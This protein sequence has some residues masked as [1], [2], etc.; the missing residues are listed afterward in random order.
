[1]N[2]YGH[3]LSGNPLA[4]LGFNQ[5][6][7]WT[8]TMFQNDDLDMFLEKPNPAN[9]DQVWSNGRWTDLEIEHEIIKVKGGKDVNLK[10]RIS[11]HGPIINDFLDTLNQEKKPVAVSWGFHDFTN[12][13][14]NGVYDLAHLDTV[15]QAPAALEKIHSPGLNFVLADVKGNIGWWAVAKLPKRPSHVDSNFILDG[16]DPANDYLGYWPFALNPQFINP[17]SGIIVSANHQPQDF[18][19]G[20]VPGYYNIENRAKRI[21][22]LLGQKENNWNANDMKTIQL[23]TESLFYKKIKDKQ[24]ALLNTIPAVQEDAVSKKA[25]EIYKNWDGFHHLD[26]LGPGIFYTF[27]YYLAK[28]IFFDELNENL[29][30][31]FL[32]TRLPDRAIS[33]LMD[34]ETSPWWDDKNTSKKESQKDILLSAWF[35]T[36]DNLKE[37]AGNDPEKWRWDNFH[38]VEYVHAIG[39]KKPLDKITRR[40]FDFGDPDHSFGINPTGQCGYF[41]DPHF[42]DQASMYISGKYRTQLTNKTDIEKA[43]VSILKFTP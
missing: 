24:V 13:F 25:F 37:F 30:K 34:L 35:Q 4:L 20:T 12:D 16:S 36:I 43:T 6:V 8:L 7:A 18:G 39:R 38:T 15:F 1:L 42:D 26:T 22:T 21:E 27:H 41:F 10:I 3:F 17:S 32:G 29:F 5:K 19:N 28:K 23:D 11:R 2:F 33:R 40:I 14:L 9:P 31:A